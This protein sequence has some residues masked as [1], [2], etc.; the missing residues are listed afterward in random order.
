MSTAALRLNPAAL[1]IVLALSLGVLVSPTVI[2]QQYR[3]EVKELD[4]PPAQQ[5]QQ[6]AAKLLQGTT[7]P[8]A[9]S[10][11]L[12]DLAAQAAQKGD[13]ARAAK[14][15]EQALSQNALSGLAAEQMRRDLAQL[16]L[17]GGDY[18]KIL[19]QLEA[20]VKTGKAPA[21]VLVALG[22]AYVEKGR[23]KDAIPLLQKAIAATPKPD[24]SWRRALAAA[25][26]GA[27]RE[28]EALP[29]LEQLLKDDP[30]QR[31]D[32]LRL[33]AL[34]AK[35]GDK[36]R[37]AA[38]MEL[39]SRLGFLKS[40]QE[41]L[42][43]VTLVA[44][45]GAPFEAASV[46]Q[47][48]MDRKLVPVD[49]ANARLKASLWLAARES[50]LA[51]TALGDALRLDPSVELYRQKAQLHMDREEYPQAAEALEQAL[52]RGK[53][54]GNTLMT[55]GM[56]R[57]QQADT[58]GATAAFQAA[59]SYPASRQ[60][61]QEWVKY[62]ETGK[63]R[64]QALAAAAERR[65]RQAEVVRLS[66][67]LTGE[68]VTLTA[69][70]GAEAARPATAREAL[71]PVGA[72]A[73]GNRD[74]SVAA[75]AGGLSR[76][77]WPASFKPGSRLVDP[78]PDDK[79]LFTITAA[80][81]E[82]YRD[83][84]SEGHRALLARY[85]SYRMPVYPPRRSVAYPPAIYEATQA[86]IGRAKLLGSDALQGA[87]L[88]FPFP[89]PQS[90]VEVMWN[91]RARYRGNSV[92]LQTTQAVVRDGAEPQLLKQSERVWFRYGNVKDPSDLTTDKILLYYLTWFGR[93]RNEVDFL[94]LVHE[95]ANSIESPRNIWVLPPKIPRM[96]R[97]PPVGYDQPFPGAEGLM[98]I[99]MVDMY[100]GAFDRYV[101]KLVGKRE[102][103]V[104]YNS[105]RAN[106]GRYSYASLL[107]RH[108]LNP[109]ATRYELHRV[110]VIEATE[111]P[112]RRHSFGKR[113]FYVDEDSWNVLLVENEDR[114]GRLWRFQEGHLLPIYDAM[115]AN[116][117]PV[118]TYDLKDGRYFANRLS[119][120]DPP[121][122]YDLPMKAA[123]FLPAAVKSRYAR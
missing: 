57:Y 62:L 76:A 37:A 9:R 19:P 121:P 55:L 90:G 10:L 78:Y 118:V 35:F 34:Q 75:W 30:S 48:W 95:T 36:P 81:A 100:N 106:D 103:Y 102:L 61:A 99:D 69:G 73:P 22:A 1:A 21:E 70:D 74:G 32:W 17:S 64:E 87:R 53:P 31:E 84:L 16:Y 45:V 7:D 89:K 8:Y 116:T 44:Q 59:A 18:Q 119:G 105:Y 104:P 117:A 33:A 2:A 110:W 58:E 112:G 50:G 71:T 86:N 28:K 63:A 41:R 80:S 93:S 91:H 83:R 26:M 94:A 13:T 115:A 15:L 46:L 77:Q 65:S 3:S 42:Q 97:I 43:L 12:R 114:E 56:A 66:G 122:Q 85:P 52:E 23:H 88:G 14:Y 72:E 101:W 123:E 120:E 20:Q 79:P 49:A 39:A 60:L 5:P 40:P 54:D 92:L 107:Q 82:R 6:D 24:P 113:T 11:L 29:L 109:E 25:L 4:T 38:L 111:R 108:H 47:A 68:S 96:F 27:G 51:L 98:F 67:R